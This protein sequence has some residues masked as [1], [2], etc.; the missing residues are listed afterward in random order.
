MQ[1]ARN[2][3]ARLSLPQAIARVTVPSSTDE[4]LAK[5]QLMLP[6]LAATR[7]EQRGT[8][9]ALSNV[10]GYLTA[11][12]GRDP[13]D[14]AL[15]FVQSSVDV[16][17]LEPADLAEFVVTDVVPNR[18]TG[19]THVYV[20]QMLGGLPVYNALLQVNINRDGRIASVSNQ[21]VRGLA[22][23]V[24]VA[25]PEISAA[26]AVANAAAH[27]GQAVR[28]APQVASVNADV[29][30][31]TTL[32][33]ASLSRAPITATLMYLPTQPG[34][35]RLVWNFQIETLDRHHVYDFTADAASGQVWTRFDWVAGDGYRVF[36]SRPQATESPSQATP[37]A[38]ADGRALVDAASD[39]VASPFGW[40]D[41]NG[42][43]GAEY[44][45]M[46]GNNAHAYA[47]PG[48][49]N[50][51]PGS[52]P[53]CSPSLTCDFSLDLQAEPDAYTSASIANLFYWTNI[54][55][56]VQYRYG[57]TEEAG[58]FQASNY[59][60]GGFADDEVQA[61]AQDGLLVAGRVNNANFLTPP[62]GYHPRMQT[63]TW[64]HTAPRRDGSLD[65]GVIAHEYGHG[66]S[67]RLVGGPSNVS[68][69]GNRQQ[70]GEGISDWLALVYTARAGDTAATGRGIATYLMGQ[71]PNGLGIRAQRYSTDPAV[72]TWTYGSIRN[73]AIPHAVGAVWA[74][75]SWEMYWALVNAHGFDADLYN[76]TGSAGNQRAML[77]VTEGLMNTPC[78]P[79]FTDL[80]DGI[81]Q[82]ALDNHGGSD[83]CRLWRSFAAF[84]LGADAVSGGPDSLTPTEGFSVP[85]LCAPAGAPTITI[86]SVTVS[87]ARS[88]ASFTVFLSAPTNVPVTVRYLT[89]DGTAHSSQTSAPYDY[90]WTSGSVVIPAFAF[91]QSV[92]VPLSPDMQ[93]EPRETFTLHLTSSLNAALGNTAGT[94]TIVDDDSPPVPPFNPLHDLVYDLGPS[95]TWLHANAVAPGPGWLPVHHANPSKMMAVDVDGNDLADL[96]VEF[97]GAGIWLLSDSTVWT[98]VHFLNSSD[99]AVGDLDGNGLDDLIFT[100][101]GYG[102]YALFN[103]SMWMAL[104]HLPS[105][106]LVVG[107]LDKD[108]RH[109]DELVVNFPGLGVWAWANNSRWEHIHGLN[110]SALAVGDLDGNGSDDLLL[111]FPGYGLWARTNEGASWS[112]V[113]PLNSVRLSLGNIDGDPGRQSDIIVNFRGYGLWALFNRTQWVHLH[114]ADVSSLL[115]TD[116]DGNGQSDLVMNFPG[117]GLWVL[118]NRTIWAQLLTTNTEG[119]VSARIDSR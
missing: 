36:P 31:T 20:R 50:E 39:L 99:M 1:S 17:G 83:Y 63:F 117:A 33:A 44:E 110:A 56:D 23:A 93:V 73:L 7:D 76:A 29:S 94:A 54:L 114:S 64:T 87:E 65:A 22:S 32:A 9:R 70:P 62:D 90:T 77:Y 30:R 52:E 85:G 53:T 88:V 10:A 12:D 15:A 11:P 95:G 4:A 59:G 18:T 69:L 19:S 66:I 5:L 6:A 8:T 86:N 102:V 51:P 101:P 40:H 24:G 96:V 104:H 84:G 37:P 119:V 21:F 13:L 38:P 3:D 48:N 55:H 111:D 97:P 105:A 46:R 78:S 92:D 89:A 113:H 47:D 61:E 16:L 74:Q 79:S 108:S 75:A 112:L 42:E 71:P 81:L 80:R 41:S 2:F 109:R 14:I 28:Q 57:F 68:C 49:I 25:Q 100:F 58:N 103:R 115:T 34:E 45:I 60:H 35:V 82:A 98:S 118:V 67:N 116:L 107:D 43:V 26:R 106:G 91:A 72:N 27:L